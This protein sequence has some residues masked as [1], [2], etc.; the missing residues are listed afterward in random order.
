MISAGYR[1]FLTAVR[2]EPGVRYH[3]SDHDFGT[4]AVTFRTRTCWGQ[5]MPEVIDLVHNSRIDS[6]PVPLGRGASMTFLHADAHHSSMNENSIVV[7]LDLGDIRILLTGDAEAG[8]RSAP[9]NAPATSSIEGTLIVCCAGDLAADVLVV[10]HHGSMTSSRTAFL[11]AIGADTYVVSSGPMQYGSVVLPDNVVITE[12][13]SRGMVFRT[14][15]DDTACATDT[16]KVGPDNDDEA[17]GCDNVRITITG[18]A[19]VVAEY[20]QP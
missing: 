14:D 10:G 16:D 19:T 18:G 1:A 4:H 13:E 8:G 11:D 3:T 17:G 6:S 2:D 5:P 9:S 20:V 15:L 12:L 7:R